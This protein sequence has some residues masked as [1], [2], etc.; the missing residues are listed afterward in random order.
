MKIKL[1]SAPK[2]VY[3]IEKII[4]YHIKNDEVYIVLNDDKYTIGKTDQQIIQAY[5]QLKADHEK[6]HEEYNGVCDLLSELED[7]D[8][9]DLDS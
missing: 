8:I 2:T 1:I 6:L 4:D 7:V 9:E 5:E 3:E